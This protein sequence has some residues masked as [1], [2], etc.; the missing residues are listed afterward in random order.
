MPRRVFRKPAEVCHDLRL[1]PLGQL[2][3]HEQV[4]LARSARLLSFEAGERLWAR[5]ELGT[6]ACILDGAFDIVRFGVTV[7]TVGYGQVLG[8]SAL[9]GEPHASDVRARVT[10]KGRAPVVAVWRVDAPAVSQLFGS[11]KLLRIFLRD[12]LHLV[13]HLNDLQIL[14]RRKRPAIAHVAVHLRRLSQCHA[15][16][17]EVEIG[18]RELGRLAG[19]DPRT[20]RVAMATLQRMGCVAV[21]RRSIYEVDEAALSRLI[22][23]ALH[24]GPG[25]SSEPASAAASEGASGPVGGGP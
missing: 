4:A 24:D 23:R 17:N 14:Y 7:D 9:W 1:T 19:Y 5:G 8:H 25:V 12:A 2:D 13:H 11:S 3:V 22:G 15:F 16:R 21:K 20:V 6:F 18:Q 10:E